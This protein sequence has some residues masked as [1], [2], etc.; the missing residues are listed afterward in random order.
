VCT[1]A[2]GGAYR[3]LRVPAEELHDLRVPLAELYGSE[4]AELREQLLDAR[5]A[6]ARFDR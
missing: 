2:P 3:F 4:A 6:A 1:S 5:P